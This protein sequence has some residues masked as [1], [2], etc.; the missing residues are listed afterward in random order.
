MSSNNLPETVLDSQTLKQV[1]NEI[2]QELIEVLNQSKLSKVLEKYGISKSEVLKINYTLD[3]NKLQ[4]TDVSEDKVAIE[5]FSMMR[6]P[7]IQT[8][9]ALLYP[10]PM[11]GY[12][13]G[14]WVDL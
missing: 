6:M 2:K 14:C 5:S 4:S 8:N 10:C 12:P 1:E 13:D 11:E 9:L 7:P 3:L